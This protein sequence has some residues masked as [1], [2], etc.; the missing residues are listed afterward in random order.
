MLPY[1]EGHE[2]YF[3][4]GTLVNNRLQKLRL[5]KAQEAF[6]AALGLRVFTSPKASKGE[7]RKRNLSISIRA[8]GLIGEKGDSFQLKGRC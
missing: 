5:I 6:I 3:C 7:R 2:R 4:T 8:K 1:T